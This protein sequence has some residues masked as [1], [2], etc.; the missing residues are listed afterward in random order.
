[1]KKIY[2]MVGLLSCVSYMSYGAD[3]NQL[4]P[5]ETSTDQKYSAAVAATAAASSAATQLPAA[6]V[7]M[8]NDAVAKAEAALTLAKANATKPLS[9]EE[10]FKA[11]QLQLMQLLVASKAR[12]NGQLSPRTN[13]EGNQIGQTLLANLNSNPDCIAIVLS[14]KEKL[15]DGAIARHDVDGALSLAAAGSKKYSVITAPPAFIASKLSQD[16][17]K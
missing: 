2:V 15:S 12:N 3:K 16:A 8:R 4:K 9:V 10:A 14:L 11:I 17:P 6:V 13:A 7:A 1:M 5:K